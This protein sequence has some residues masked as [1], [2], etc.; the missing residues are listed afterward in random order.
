[1]GEL[2]QDRTTLDP[3]LVVEY[4]NERAVL[5]IWNGGQLIASV[6]MQA[7]YDASSRRPVAVEA[8]NST[9]ALNSPIRAPEKAAVAATDGCYGVQAV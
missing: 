8:A 2:I 1:M 6:G 5:G 4:Q 3:Y 7:S 9:G